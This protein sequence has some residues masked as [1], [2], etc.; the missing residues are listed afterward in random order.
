VIA[1]YDALKLKVTVSRIDVDANG[2]ATIVWSDT[3]GGTARPVG[4]SATLPGALNVPNSSLIWSEVSYGYTPTIG[5][6]VIGTLHLS[7]QFYMRPRVSD[8]VQRVNS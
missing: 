7:D 5:Y 3:L 2:N 8:K 6:I 1:P 4:S